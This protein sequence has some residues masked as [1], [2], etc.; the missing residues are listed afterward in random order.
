[1]KALGHR[2]RA[3][4]GTN[5]VT[6]NDLWETKRGVQGIRSDLGSE[7]INDDVRTFCHNAGIRHTFTGPYAPQQHG[8]S[9]R[10]NRTLFNIVRAMLQDSNLTKD[11]RAEALNTAAVFIVNRLPS[12]GRVSPFDDEFLYERPP[13]LTN[14]RVFGCRAYVH[15]PKGTL[16]KLDPRAWEGIMVGYNEMNWRCY[17]IYNPETATVRSAII[18]V[19]FDELM[20]PKP[21]RVEEPE[22]NEDFTEVLTHQTRITGGEPQ[23]LGMYLGL[24]DYQNQLGLRCQMQRFRKIYYLEVVWRAL[25]NQ[26]GISRRSEFLYCQEDLN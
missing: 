14:L 24:E 21:V 16:R 25:W 13:K 19:T 18:H 6:R 10:R 11:F 22:S 15:Y 17:R 5:G 26:L 4:W 3:L 2:V 12:R 23:K 7:F 9:E 8:I 1:M 20:R